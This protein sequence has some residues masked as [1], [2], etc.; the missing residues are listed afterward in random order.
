MRLRRS[1]KPSPDAAAQALAGRLRESGLWSEQP[2]AV[3]E[4]NLR[5]VAGGGYPFGLPGCE[6]FE[7]FADGE[8]LA[9]GGVEEFL[10]TLRGPLMRFGI[11]LEVSSVADGPGY[12]VMINGRRCVVLDD[13]DDPDWLAATVRPLAV[14]NALLDEAHASHRMYLLYAGGNEGIALLLPPAAVSAI[15]DS[16]L[17]DPTEIPQLA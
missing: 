10:E 1:A 6:E 17:F 12:P 7:F 11:N 16:G 9:E 15:S 5:A 3:R 13:A 4:Q 2:A 14:V 8:D